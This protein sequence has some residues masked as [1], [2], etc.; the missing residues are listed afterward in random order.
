MKYRL[1]SI[2]NHLTWEIT[3]VLLI[4]CHISVRMLKLGPHMKEK[5][6]AGRMSSIRGPEHQKFTPQ[7]GKGFRGLASML[8]ENICWIGVLKKDKML[9]SRWRCFLEDWLAMFLL[10]SLYCCWDD[11]LGCLESCCSW[12]QTPS[13]VHCLLDCAAS[14][15]LRSKNS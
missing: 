14:L 7:L 11:T 1:W 3:S 13:P 4:F 15:P 6:L 10:W 2:I 5:R 12:I 8:Q 9:L